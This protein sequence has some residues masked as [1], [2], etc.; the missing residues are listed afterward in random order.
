MILRAIHIYDGCRTEI[1]DYDK[2]TE[3]IRSLIS[4]VTIDIRPED[5]ILGD[6][7][8]IARIFA[9]LRLRDIMKGRIRGEP[10]PAEIDYELRR[11][12][13]KKNKTYGILYDGFQVAKAL[14]ENIRVEEDN[15]EHLHI[16]VT[17]QLIGSFDDNDRRF[18]ARYAIFS[19]P[20]IISV[21]G[22]V[23]APAKPR[24]YYV[25]KQRLK[26]FEKDE[27]FDT[28][29]KEQMKDR[30]IDYDDER[31]NDVMKG[32]ILQCI[33]YHE[34]G[35]PFCESRNCR[36]FNAHWQEELIVSQTQENSSLCPAHSEFI[37]KNFN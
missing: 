6:Y 29:I 30:F 4:S 3:Y 23:V 28:I 33:F 31:L 15:P 12:T 19:Y 37:K 10:L 1:L 9:E 7:E 25:L 35:Y 13:D 18:H 14:E 17:N 11:L 34:T 5:A 20:C 16:Y 24:E 27:I 8:K 32:I 21:T 36:L 22:I 26:N 2:I